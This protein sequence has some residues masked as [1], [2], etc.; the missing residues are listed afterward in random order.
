MKNQLNRINIREGHRAN[1]QMTSRYTNE[2]QVRRVLAQLAG[3]VKFAMGIS[4]NVAYQCYRDAM[5]LI[6]KH[7]RYRQ[8]IKKEF[9]KVEEEW[10]KYENA[11]LYASDNRFFCVADMDDNTRRKYKADLTDR[12]YYEWWQATGQDAYSRNQAY[13][14]SMANKYRKSLERHGGKNPD[15]IGWGMVVEAMLQYAGKTY[16]ST[17]TQIIAV[18][19]IPKSIIIPIFCGFSLDPIE[20]AWFRA[21]SLL[22]PLS[23]DEDIDVDEQHDIELGLQSLEE[24]FF[25]INAMYDSMLGAVEDYGEVFAS[26][27]FQKKTLRE[28]AENKA[29]VNSALS[30]H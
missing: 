3:V 6:R 13:I 21:L 12:E 5:D 8:N 22:E 10:R 24:K 25:D 7:P 26:K 1:L 16:N 20:K 9:G 2:L 17:M 4:N 28:I 11:L 15:I 18:S 29:D 27:G 23:T 14:K 19:G 30:N